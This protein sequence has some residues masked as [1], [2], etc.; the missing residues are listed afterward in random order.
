MGEG[1]GPTGA[2]A[3]WESRQVLN[4][5]ESQNED[6][7]VVV[8]DASERQLLGDAEVRASEGRG[9]GGRADTR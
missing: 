2:S 7:N 8:T 4:P 1:A 5:E 9:A 6:D 3:I